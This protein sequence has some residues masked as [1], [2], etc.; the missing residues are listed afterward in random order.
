MDIFSVQCKST[1][2]V[3]LRLNQSLFSVSMCV[4]NVDTDNEA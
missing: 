3:S 4:V 2:S 1:Y